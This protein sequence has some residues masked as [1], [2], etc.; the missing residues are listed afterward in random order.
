M[1]MICFKTTIFFLASSLLFSCNQT[2]K[3]GND[4]STET[5]KAR[6][7]TPAVSTSHA[8]TNNKPLSEFGEFIPAGYEILYQSAGKLDLDHL[9]DK[10]LVLK[11]NGEDSLSTQETPIK[12]K[13]LILLGQADGSFKLK[14]QNENLVYHYAYDLNFKEALVGIRIQEGQFSVDHYGGF[15][16][17]WGRTTTF[18]YNSAENNWFVTEDEHSSFKATDPENT[19]KEKV[20]TEKDFGK[21]VFEKFDIYKEWK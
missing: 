17:R 1:I 4:N 21:I 11:K 2:T 5:D 15:A 3:Q 19:Q 14:A 6:R 12:R 8:V 18:K 16:D 9:P 7:D 13:S 20:Y 10:I